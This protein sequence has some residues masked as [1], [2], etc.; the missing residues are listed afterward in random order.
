MTNTSVKELREL[1]FWQEADLC[2][3]DTITGKKK[4][5]KKRK[6]GLKKKIA[7][8][9]FT[10]EVFEAFIYGDGS[11][12]FD[13]NTTWNDKLEIWAS[14][15]M[16][17]K[18]IKVSQRRYNELFCLGTKSRHC[19]AEWQSEYKPYWHPD[20]REALHRNLILS[21]KAYN[22]AVQVER[23]STTTF[24]QPNFL[25]LRHKYLDDIL[26]RFQISSTGDK[27]GAFFGHT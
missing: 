10:R 9:L 6:R 20:V 23:S 25:H 21:I 18:S 8:P 13:M 19:L 4:R 5:R 26:S 27:N 12:M 16:S 17:L 7:P 24:P 11:L 22:V 3:G 1:P 15:G 2:T 14:Y